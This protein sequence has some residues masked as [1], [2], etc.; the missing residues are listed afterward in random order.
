MCAAA[1]SAGRSPSASPRPLQTD[2]RQHQQTLEQKDRIETRI[3]RSPSRDSVTTDLSLMSLSSLGSS[4]SKTPVK[5]ETTPIPSVP[6]VVKS[7]YRMSAASDDRQSWNGTDIEDM[8]DQSEPIR[9]PSPNPDTSYSR[10]GGGITVIATNIGNMRSSS[11]SSIRG[12]RNNLQVPSEHYGLLGSR[13]G[14][15]GL[16]ETLFEEESDLIRSC[17]ALSSVLGLRRSFSTSDITQ[18]TQADPDLLKSSASEIVLCSS[19]SGGAG[20][21]ARDDLSTQGRLDYASRSCSTWVAVGDMASTSQLPS[22]QGN[23]G[24]VSDSPAITAAEFVRSVNKKVRQTYIKRR[25]LTTY[26]ALERIA[27][28]ELNLQACKCDLAALGKV[29]KSQVSREI[30]KLLRK[31]FDPHGPGLLGAVKSLSLTVKDVE[32]EKGKPL[33]KY[34][35]N[36]MIFNWLHSLE[37]TTYDRL[38]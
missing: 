26:K 4:M 1:N 20:G 13:K 34:E 31:D 23:P 6:E 33:T 12:S 11:S 5:M 9:G 3:L 19:G 28:S 14:I 17:G 8:V 27:Q 37:D 21:G 18:T 10:G 2:Y 32:R 16:S 36:M 30:L 7:N 29:S 24:Q 38:S 15:V 22:P 25:L 35:R